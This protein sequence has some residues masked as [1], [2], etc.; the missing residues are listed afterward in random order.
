MKSRAPPSFRRLSSPVHVCVDI[1]LLMCKPSEHLVFSK[2]AFEFEE[3]ELLSK[4]DSS[5][6]DGKLLICIHFGNSS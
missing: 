6:S 2:K 5:Q 4:T 3:T 1:S